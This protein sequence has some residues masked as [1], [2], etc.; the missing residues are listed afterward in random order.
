MKSMERNRRGQGKGAA[1]LA[2]LGT[3]SIVMAMLITLSGR[4]S[5]ERQRQAQRLWVMQAEQFLLVGKRRC[6]VRLQAAPDYRGETWECPG[7]SEAIADDSEG[8]ATI[9]IE[10]NAGDSAGNERG[11]LIRVHVVYPAGNPVAVR[12]TETFYVDG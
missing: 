10:T 9:E 11:V 7:P 12:L 5:L 1:L 3:L 8:R 6:L 4:L 2:V